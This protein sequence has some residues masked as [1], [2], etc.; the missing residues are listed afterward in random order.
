[1]NSSFDMR[2]HILAVA[3]ALFYEHGIGAVGVD[4][5]ISDADVAKATLYRHFPTK[6]DLVLA[7][8]ERRKSIAISEIRETIKSAG[9]DS[10]A[11]VTSIFDRLAIVSRRGFRGCAFLRA[12]AEHLKSESIHA[13]VKGHKDAIRGLFEEAVAGLPV[14]RAQLRDVAAI[15]ALIYD[16]ALA[17]VTV[18]K[19]PKAI[20]FAQQAALA[21]LCEVQ[22]GAA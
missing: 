17:V 16:G 19:D 10:V 9:E 18:Q 6:E 20:R 13:A 11:R 3:S 2:D 14:T 15:L 8:L 4:W 12:Q 22:N 7:Y 5:V 21:T 1:M